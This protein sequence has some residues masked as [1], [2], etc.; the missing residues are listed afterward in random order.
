MN[1]SSHPTCYLQYNTFALDSVAS[2][3][4]SAFYYSIKK[5]FPSV[6]LS[7]YG[8]HKWSDKYKVIGM[9]GVH[10][11]IFSDESVYGTHKSRKYMGDSGK[12]HIS[13]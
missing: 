9:N 12:K 6:I 11:Q 7:D 5:Y 3:F 4:D 2:L 13:R 8:F 10:N 1:W